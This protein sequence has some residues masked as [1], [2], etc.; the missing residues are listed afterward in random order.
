M[1]SMLRGGIPFNG[2]QPSSTVQEGKVQFAEAMDGIVVLWYTMRDFFFH[3]MLIL[4]R[5]DTV[6]IHIQPTLT[7][8]PFNAFPR[9]TKY[10]SSHFHNR[11]IK[12]SSSCS[13]S[14][15]DV[16]M[17]AIILMPLG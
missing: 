8:S 17:L 15:A 2:K 13:H 6:G 14:G 16:F 11:G 7:Q 12:L 9:C 5:G 4:A 3:H 10:G 1:H